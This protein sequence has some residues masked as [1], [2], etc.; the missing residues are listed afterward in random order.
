MNEKLLQFKILLEWIIFND[1]VMCS[2]QLCDNHSNVVAKIINGFN[3]FNC[4]ICTH[5]YRFALLAFQKLSYFY[6]CNCLKQSFLSMT[7]L[8]SIVLIFIFLYCWLPI[9]LKTWFS[10]I[11]ANEDQS[12]FSNVPSISFKNCL[13]KQYHFL[14]I[15][16]RY[17]REYKC[18]STW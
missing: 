3:N 13:N 11:Q 15:H 14:F 1:W 7:N 5:K 12:R 17:A 18:I 10:C 4:T 6:V 2:W 9:I 16:H 8:L